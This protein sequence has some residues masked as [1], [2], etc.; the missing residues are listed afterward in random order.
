MEFLGGNSS[1]SM[2]GGRNGASRQTGSFGSQISST[3]QSLDNNYLLKQVGQF[4]ATTK[5]EKISREKK[6]EE[7]SDSIQVKKVKFLVWK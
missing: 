3:T 7:L 6:T 4:M 1:D 5:E 2:S